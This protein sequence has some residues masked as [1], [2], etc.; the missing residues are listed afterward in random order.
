M[1]Y[2]FLLSTSL[3]LAALAVTQ[4]TRAAE[5][6]MT[7]IKEAPLKNV[8][9]FPGQARVGRSWTTAV[10]AGTQSLVLE[11]LEYG[12]NPASVQVSTSTPGITVRLVE[13]GAVHVKNILSEQAKELRAMIDKEEAATHA[14][15]D[16]LRILEKNENLLAGIEIGRT[17]IGNPQTDT[18]PITVDP[19][20]WGLIL[21]DMRTQEQANRKKLRELERKLADR[22]I[23]MQVLLDR[24]QRLAAFEVMDS[25]L[26]TLTVE[27]QNAGQAVFDISY[28]VRGPG[29]FPQ[30]QARVDRKAGTLEL[31]CYSMIFQGTGRNWADA[32]LNVSTANPDESSN[33]PELSAWFLRE[34]LNPYLGME[35]K[36]AEVD[37]IKSMAPMT[38]ALH[39]KIQLESIS[40]AE[41]GKGYA[42][43]LRKLNSAERQE[44]EHWEKKQDEEVRDAAANSLKD[45]AQLQGRGSRVVREAAK[46]VAKENAEIFSVLRQRLDALKPRTV[47]P[48]TAPVVEWQGQS[49]CLPHS[50]GSWYDQEFKAL[51][52]G[53][54]P[55]TSEP[56][57]VL[58]SR[59]DFKGRF[60]HLVRPRQDTRAFL[61]AKAPN[62]SGLSWL[63]G[64][65]R[66]FFQNDYV[67][68]VSFTGLGDKGEMELS[69]G[70]DENLE[71]ER[72]TRT[73]DADPGLFGSDRRTTV[74]VT[75][76]LKN[77][78]DED[79][80][81]VI[82]ESLPFT[83]TSET[84]V[85]LL[86]DGATDGVRLVKNKANLL[87]WEA[88]LK[89]G[90]TKLY[91]WSYA[92]THDEE[93]K[94]QGLKP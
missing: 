7:E 24:I 8:T 6:D 75:L 79:T 51:T 85:E 18:A 29:W 13:V 41:S 33:I 37:G 52:P 11:G 61:I 50:P 48:Q 83:Q 25:K 65:M 82:E 16:E 80:T 73:F 34:N 69:L 32:P 57:R 40:R 45:M 21:D 39:R 17:P 53:T 70:V 9:V 56:V 55:S 20:R 3:C 64:G 62:T 1:N 35:D 4:P 63:P 76:E 68:Q 5:P 84:K 23:E 26:M 43:D 46:S 90:E 93:L 42:E 72:R 59:H 28:Q 92:I 10:K 77:L 86:S 81:V 49:V 78:G 58:L 15:T 66:V 94:I 36:N 22:Q 47:V 31:S 88:A 87:Q 44:I 19:A 12:L 30:Y 74:E 60:H 54:I 38:K 71:V 2:R 89:K 67:G 14:L 27:A 91:T